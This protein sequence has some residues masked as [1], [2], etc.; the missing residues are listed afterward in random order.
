VKVFNLDLFFTK[1]ID[2]QGDLLNLPIK[3]ETIDTAVC[4][5]VLEHVRKPGIAVQK[6][7]RVLKPWGCEFIETPFMQT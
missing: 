5:G 3:D 7:Y 4:T 1:K 2:I 6:I